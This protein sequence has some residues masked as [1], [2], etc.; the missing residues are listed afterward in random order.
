MP[1]RLGVGRSLG[2][3][4]VAVGAAACLPTRGSEDADANASAITEGGA[5][6][7]DGHADSGAFDADSG[8][9]DADSGAFDADSGAFDADSGAFDADSGSFDADGMV[10]GSTVIDAVVQLDAD[11]SRDGSSLP[12][13]GSLPDVVATDAGACVS[14]AHLV[15]A[16]PVC[17]GGVRPIVPS[18]LSATT[19]L[20]PR[21]RFALPGGADG[22]VVDFCR[23]RA[24]GSVI[25]SVHVSGTT[26]QPT[27][28]LPV[29]TTVFWRARA[30]VGAVEDS[31][32]GPTWLF[33]TPA[34]NASS[35]VDVSQQAR[36]D[37][38]GDG[39]DDVLYA[40]PGNATATT[41]GLIRIHWG[42]SGGVAMAPSQTVSGVPGDDFKFGAAVHC[43][44]DVN[45]DGYGDVIVGVPFV[46]RGPYVFVG[47][48]KLFLGSSAGLSA[49]PAATLEG[50]L[51]DGYFGGT[52]LIGGDVNG[53]GYADVFVSAASRT[54][55]PLLQQGEVTLF[56][57]TASGI[58]T[59]PTRRYQGA[60]VAQQLGRTLQAVGDIN[61]DGYA[62]V[63]ISG[64]QSM[65]SMDLFLGSAAGLPDT[66]QF[67]L[68][69][70]E[71]S[72]YDVNGDGYADMLRRNPVAPISVL[73]GA[74]GGLSEGRTAP[75]AMVMNPGVSVPDLNGDG[76]ADAL[77]YDQRAGVGA[78]PF[79]GRL[80]VHLGSAAGISAS[81]AQVLTGT[82]PYEGFGG[83]ENWADVN[84]DGYADAFVLASS[85]AL[86]GP[87]PATRYLYLGGASGLRTPAA[88]SWTLR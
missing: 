69:Q 28:P 4:L 76:F 5:D 62:D 16:V 40:D 52:V 71:G 36:C 53:D 8:A 24:C 68:E 66:P 26:A 61:A 43:N 88:Q 10:D 3:V 32:F 29:R 70:L 34:L 79:A 85:Q 75:Y 44:G 60:A 47:R 38:N 18:S 37:V 74:S 21:V 31:V 41:P 73:L 81:A 1:I 82:M 6:G 49:A 86:S 2:C 13:V 63:V 51:D 83:V 84:G 30:R 15:G 58:S 9:F 27:A 67:S 50:P 22:A 59:L 11:A 57:G 72:A 39:F 46:A 7:S 23:D 64:T 20:R 48:A 17:N 12:D 14:G 54:L 87:M 19:N 77:V 80:S 65:R 33:H 55:P 78:I 56:H 45:G 35:G 42:N 25:E